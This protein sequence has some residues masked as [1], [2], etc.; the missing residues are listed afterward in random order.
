MH[1]G[2]PFGA[3]IGHTDFGDGAIENAVRQT[4]EKLH[5]LP[6]GVAG[7]APV[8]LHASQMALKSLATG[9]KRLIQAP[10]T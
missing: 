5:L 6:R 4:I 2:Q 8:Q 3:D 10:T 1:P 9:L 7:R